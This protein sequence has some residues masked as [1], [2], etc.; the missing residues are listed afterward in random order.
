V[1]RAEEA[2]AIAERREAVDKRLMQFLD[3]TVNQFEAG[4]HRDKKLE[5]KVSLLGRRLTRLDH[6]RA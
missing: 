1:G 6:A 2:A 4:A 5:E 3:D